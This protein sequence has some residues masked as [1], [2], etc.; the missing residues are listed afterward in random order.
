MFRMAR[1]ESARALC[2]PGPAQAL[3]P[4]QMP[5]AGWPD[6]AIALAPM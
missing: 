1:P 2:G 4:P 6:K 3:V 5:V